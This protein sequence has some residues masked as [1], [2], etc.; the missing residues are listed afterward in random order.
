MHIVM[1]YCLLWC[2]Q[3]CYFATRQL[4]TLKTVSGHQEG[5]GSS[6]NTQYH[7]LCVY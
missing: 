2:Q 1:V 6:E 3:S 4:S 7:N 5:I